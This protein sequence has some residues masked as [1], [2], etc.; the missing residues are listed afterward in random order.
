MAVTRRQLLGAIGAGWLA[1]PWLGGRASV[2]GRIV[3]AGH[4]LGHRLRDEARSVAPAGPA[5]RCDVVVVGSGV[6][7]ASAAWRLRACGIEP[8][9]LEH[10]PFPG[11]T[12]AWGQ[13]GVV[14]HPWG[15]HYLATPN[16]ESRVTLRLLAQTGVVTGWDAADRPVFREELLCHSPEERLFYR[17]AW[18]P[19]LVP[20]ER[21]SPSERQ[22]MAI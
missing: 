9:V 15:A 19:G 14:P 21:L 13:D 7:G 2:T 3:G 6:S 11:G 17:G 22:D 12:S 18:S 5:E 4:A 16:R 8:W 10:E 20:L 1:D